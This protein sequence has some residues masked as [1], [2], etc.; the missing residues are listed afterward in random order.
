M[1]VI[2]SLW[3]MANK[4]YKSRQIKRFLM[5]EWVMKT[6]ASLVDFLYFIYKM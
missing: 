2:L 4:G 1:S 5:Y 3:A 6:R